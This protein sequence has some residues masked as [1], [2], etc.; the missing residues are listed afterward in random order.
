[1]GV[2]S[3]NDWVLGVAGGSAANLI[4][5]TVDQSTG[6]IFARNAWTNKS[7]DEVA[8]AHLGA[9]AVRY[10]GDRR[11]FIGRNGTYQHPQA[12]SQNKALRGVVG[13]GLDPCAALQTTI[14]LKPQQEIELIILL[15]T[16]VNAGAAQTLI[17]KYTTQY[18]AKALQEVKDYWQSMLG[19]I[20]V[21]TPDRATDI[22]L[23][24]W[25]LYQ[26][27]ACRMWARS[28]F[29]QTSGAYGYRDQLQDVMTVVHC[30]PAW[31]R[32][33]IL[34]AASRQFTPGDVQ[35]W[36]LPDT[37]DVGQGIR[38]RFADDA[39]WL[40]YVTAAYI[41]VTGD[42]AILDEIIPF[43][44][45]RVLTDDESEAFYLPTVSTETATLL[46]HC[47]RAIDRSL[48]SGVHGLSLFGG[49]D[50]ND[51]MN[52]VGQGGKGESVWLSWFLLSTIKQFDPLAENLTSERRAKWQ[53]HAA[54]LTHALE[55]NAW[56]GEWYR[57]GYYDD[58]V[59]LGSAT[60]E[61]CRI[62]SIAQSWAVISGVAPPERAARAMRAVEQYLHIPDEGLAL[63]FKP[64]FN[65]TAQDPGYIKAYPPGV[66]ENG[67]Q[68]T[69]AALWSVFA[70]AQ[71]KQTE[72]AFTLFSMLNPIEHTESR[73][74]VFR[75]K[76][77]P[78]VVA[79]DIYANPQHMGRGGWTW[80]TGSAGWM[81]RAGIE[82]ILGLQVRGTLLRLVP[83]I[84]QS[85]PGFEL[86]YR[87]KSTE[88]NIEVVN[89]SGLGHTVTACAVDGV[90]LACDAPIQMSDDGRRHTVTIE[91]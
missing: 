61:E 31:T 68:Y 7:R 56:D 18:A 37:T 83:C 52:R 69:H 38:T 42:T 32:Q 71:M 85:W 48:T 44:D 33:H 19:Q 23:N 88:Y 20:Q 87:Y 41:Q 45:G 11:E 12:L 26:T 54:N 46:E 27:I 36:W 64:A 9:P 57:R 40:P 75:Y 89:R 65:L 14:V 17:K 6:G 34:R 29:Y 1:M 21:K 80:Y 25:L 47:A 49:G 67:G 13:A 8:F 39:L 62:D 28:A 66:R 51:G 55:L 43:L 76:V 16:G 53:I 15:G 24:G 79:A 58:G 73:M 78:Y 70:M 4:I 50:W 86:S 90:S 3:Y 22:M 77:E 81:Y 59:A 72:K 74:A 10:T 35:H 60:S 84:P 91:L 2:T 63:L 82:A 30:Q 5:T